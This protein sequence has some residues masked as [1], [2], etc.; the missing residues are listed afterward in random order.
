M[1]C[2]EHSQDKYLTSFN[3]VAIAALFG[4]SAL[5]V[6]PCTHV[7]ALAKQIAEISVTSASWTSRNELVL[8]GSSTDA[9]LPNQYGFCRVK[10]HIEYSGNNSLAFELWLPEQDSY[11]ERYL[12]AG[13][14]GLAG[15]I[16][17]SAMMLN[18]NRGYAVAAGDS[19]H[20]VALNGNGTTQPGQYISFLNSPAQTKAWIHN[21]IAMLTPP[22]REL[23]ALYYGSK[24]TF[25]YFSGC[26]TGGA[27][28]FALAQLHPDLFDGI[29]AGSPGNWYSHLILSFLWNAKRTKGDAF[30]DQSVLNFTTNAILAKCDS[31]DGVVD[32]L[33]E[34]PLHCPF[35]IRS[36][37]CPDSSK[38]SKSNVTCLTQP[39]IKAIEAIYAGP[40]DSRNGDV[41]YPG[42]TL[43]SEKEWLLQET[44]LYL[45]YSTP[46]LQNLVFNNMSFDIS[47]FDFG[48][49]VDK[50]DA[51]ASPLIDGISTDLSAFRKR[52]GKMIV[53]QGWTD[54]YNGALWP[55]MHLEQLQNTTA[56][57]NVSEFFNLFMIPG[58]GHCGPAS[59][60]PS[61]PSTYHADDVLRAWVENDTFPES[62]LTSRP[63][64][65]SNRTR[66][67]CPWPQNA[68]LKSPSAGSDNAESFVCA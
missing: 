56:N 63:L 66:K 57:G 24:P 25:S 29:Y 30:L 45:N 12:V 65:G 49:D 22:T 32:G 67:I 26:S 27:Q 47:Q 16:D 48:A 59:S 14:G 23:S 62:I 15:T 19:G 20:D 9:A 41:I 60:F 40:T 44:S 39:Q 3:N 5:A 28:G 51:I 4:V 37:A 11:N 18:L 21:S 7:P 61:A 55:I 13:N 54:P 53:T 8:S 58:G 36:L 31:L 33:I 46:I 34:N 17:T 1:D 10:G 42:Y 38:T 35:N 6:D 50:V 68:R 2:L 64:D 43:G 52:G